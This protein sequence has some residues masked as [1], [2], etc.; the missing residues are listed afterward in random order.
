MQ[1]AQHYLVY[2]F[3]RFSICFIQAMPLR[4]C[5][6]MAQHL[7]WVLY[8]VVKLRRDVLEDNLAHAFPELT[9]LE[10]DRLALASY[11]HMEIPLP[12]KRR[13]TC[14]NSSNIKDARSASKS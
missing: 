4:T 7:G 14:P 5:A 12:T 13:G 9:E 10:R 6:R 1:L 8:A 11:E 3:V 2:L